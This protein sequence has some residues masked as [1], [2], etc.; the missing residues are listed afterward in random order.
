[1]NV[2]LI[3]S[4]VYRC[5][6]CNSW[7]CRLPTFL[8]ELDKG[9]ICEKCGCTSFLELKG[10]PYGCKSRCW[11]KL[12]NQ[13]HNEIKLGVSFDEEEV[14]EFFIIKKLK[15]GNHDR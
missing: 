12:I 7:Y 2:R 15:G 4:T 3:K 9:D 13:L 11:E 1:M 14:N 6:R 10:R 8:A 5:T